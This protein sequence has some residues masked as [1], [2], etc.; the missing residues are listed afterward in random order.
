MSGY[1]VLAPSGVVVWLATGGFSFFFWFGVVGGGVG[2]VGGGGRVMR[3]R[4]HR[5][6]FG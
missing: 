1:L 6:C 4:H 3:G 2:G 5:F